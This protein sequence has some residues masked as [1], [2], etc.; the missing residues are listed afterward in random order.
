MISNDSD[1][2]ITEGHS[3]WWEYGNFSSKAVLGSPKP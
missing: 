1:H 3:A 2:D